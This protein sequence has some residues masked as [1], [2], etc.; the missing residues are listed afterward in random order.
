MDFTGIMLV[1][2]NAV[3]A[4]ASTYCFAVFWSG[5]VQVISTILL[6]AG[7][8]T[9]RYDAISSDVPAILCAS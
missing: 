2:F 9:V 4:T 1:V 3:F 6:F 8:D 7:E 5:L